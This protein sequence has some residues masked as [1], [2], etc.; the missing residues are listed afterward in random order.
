MQQVLPHPRQRR[1]AG[2][3][4]RGGLADGCPAGLFLLSC[5]LDLF[6]V[7]DLQFVGFLGLLDLLLQGGQILVA[8]QFGPQLGIIAIQPM[9]DL[10]VQL[11]SLGLQGRQLGRRLLGLGVFRLC[12]GCRGR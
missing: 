8:A 1:V 5:R 7:L 3:G 2:H 12:K 10:P 9:P 6:I 11:A 4:L